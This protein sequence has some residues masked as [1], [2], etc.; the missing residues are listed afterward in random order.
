MIKMITKPHQNHHLVYKILKS[1][2]FGFRTTFCKPTAPPCS[3][4]PVRAAGGSACTPILSRPGACRPWPC[5]LLRRPVAARPPGRRP[6]PAPRSRRETP[7]QCMHINPM[8]PPF[9]R[10]YVIFTTPW[11]ALYVKSCVGA[12]TTKPDRGSDVR[13][14][15]HRPIQQFFQVTLDQR[16]GRW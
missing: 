3:H 1:F 7:C 12:R 9:P 16:R 13:C 6:P 5:P 8:L 10:C 14:V 2:L 11:T 4:V 15:G